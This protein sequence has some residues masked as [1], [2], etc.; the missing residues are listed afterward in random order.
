[1]RVDNIE[2]KL[3][4]QRHNFVRERQQILRLAEQGIRRRMNAVER[5][6]GFVIAEAER[7]L[8]AD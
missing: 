3:P 8:G 2:R 7:G 5:E 4:R 6:T 1:M